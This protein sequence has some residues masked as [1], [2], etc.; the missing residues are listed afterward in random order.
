MS[1]VQGTVSQLS[2]KFRAY[3]YWQDVS[4]SQNWK[5]LNNGTLVRIMTLIDTTSASQN[6]N[7]TCSS[8]SM[9]INGSVKNDYGSFNSNTVSGWTYTAGT[10]PTGR[11]AENIMEQLSPAYYE[12]FVP[13]NADGTKT[14]WVAC[15]YS[16]SSGG[17]GPGNVSISGSIVLPSIPRESTATATNADIESATSI[18]INRY[19]ST[20]TTTLRYEFP[21]GEVGALTG[22]IVTKTPNTSVGWTVPDTFYAKIPNAINGICKI[23][24]DTY[25]GDTLIGTTSTTFTATVGAA[26]KPDVSATITDNVATALTGDN[27]KF[28]K[29]IS[30]AVF[31]ITST[32]KNSA[33]IVSRSIVCG[34]KSSTSASGT[35]TEIESA[36]FVVTT[37][38]SRG[39]SNSVT[40]TKTLIDYVK[41]TLNPTISRTTPTGDT[42]SYEINGNY[43]NNTFGSVS[44]TLKVEYRVSENG[45]TSFTSWTEITSITPSGNAYS[46][47]GILTGPFD[48][49][50]QAII[51]IRALDKVYTTSTPILR[52]LIIAR[53]IPVY[54]WGDTFFRH[55]TDV[56]FNDKK[57]IDLIHPVGS[58][59]ISSDPTSPATLFGGT[60]VSLKDRVI[61]GAGGLYTANTTG[62]S[63]THRHNFRI[64]QAY[65]YGVPVGDNMGQV[66]AYKYS[67][68]TYAGATG[69][70]GNITVAKNNNLVAGLA[71]V[72]TGTSYSQ[73]DT[74]LE[75]NLPPWEAKYMWE[76]TA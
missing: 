4:A 19:L 5:I 64:A 25:N 42:F 15:S 54:N 29:F 11:V 59:Y 46:K 60:W 44:N 50:K 1:L 18:N 3:I 61:I 39:L 72:T 17:F 7:G 26:N 49:T 35:L 28:V 2:S 33:T 52:E 67:T 9:N 10:S 14:C 53:G 57:L 6:W 13:H 75:N 40:Y 16:L 8:L 24:C 32:P 45:G 69:T 48:Y 66:G 22:T 63:L 65:Y 20:Y 36:T 68:G 27:Q 47:I 38:D 56:Y 51:Q 58:I 23:Y 30:N 34:A 73:G 41:L 55:N 21:S 76:R 71:N 37:T 62:G 43:F 74:D 70:F 12:V 31:S